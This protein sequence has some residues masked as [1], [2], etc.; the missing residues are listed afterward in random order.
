MTDFATWLRNLFAPQVPPTP[1]PPLTAPV[2]V[3][4]VYDMPWVSVLSAGGF[5]D[6]VFWASQIAEP[7]K[8]FQIDT[9]RRV[10]AFAATIGHESNGGRVLEENL[11]YSAARLVAVWPNRFPTIAAALPYAWDPSDPDREDVALANLVYGARMGNQANGTDDDDGWERRGRGLIQLTG[12]QA[13]ID[14]A[15]A[16]GKPFDTHP[17]LAAQPAHAAAIAC[18]TWAQWKGCNRLADAGDVNGW[19]RAINGGLNGLAD[20]QARYAAALRV[21]S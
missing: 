12:M 11:R 9:P 10:A 5:T 13:Y 4:P 18:W 1:A 21:M 8:R 2:P 15:R 16:L 3:A 20:V 19:R 7:A 17:D 14:A 6:P